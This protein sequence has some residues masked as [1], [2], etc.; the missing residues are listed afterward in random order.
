[1]LFVDEIHS[2]L[3]SSMHE[4]GPFS[5]ANESFKAALGHG[6]FACIGCTTTAEF[7]YFIERDQ[8]LARRFG[9]IRLEPPRPEAAVRILHARRPAMA[10]SLR[11]AAHPRRDPRRAVELTEQYLLPSR[12][13]PDKSH[14]AAGRG[15]RLLRDGGAAAGGGHRG[16]AAGTG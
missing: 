8:A 2:F 1:M 12:F 10:Q 15:L 5:D 16:R 6:D 7:R 4:R 13:Q 11:P 9:V 14:P 3:Q